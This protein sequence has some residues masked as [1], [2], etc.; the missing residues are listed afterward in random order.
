MSFIPSEIIHT[1]L[2]P[3]AESGLAVHDL[4]THVTSKSLFTSII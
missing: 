3:E 2:L 1:L 4:A